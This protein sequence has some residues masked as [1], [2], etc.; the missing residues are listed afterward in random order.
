MIDIQS[1]RY[2]E[3]YQEH[4]VVVLSDEVSLV[5]RESFFVREIWTEVSFVEHDGIQ[6][7]GDKISDHARESAEF[8]HITKRKK[9]N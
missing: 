5:N 3:V 2:F 7:N 8:K 4:T 1:V 9:R 6:Q